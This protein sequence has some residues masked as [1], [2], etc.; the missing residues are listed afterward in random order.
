[1]VS[2]LGV[3]RKRTEVRILL[4]NGKRIKLATSK[5]SKFGS[6]GSVDN[7]GSS[8]CKYLGPAANLG[9]AAIRISIMDLAPP[10]NPAP[11][12]NLAPAASSSNLATAALSSNLAPAAPSANSA[13]PV[14]LAP[15]A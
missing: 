12:S 1:M 15:A 11:S 8:V 2:I 10:A 13:A 14:P 9:P 6:C 3:C 4:E 5:I 7:C